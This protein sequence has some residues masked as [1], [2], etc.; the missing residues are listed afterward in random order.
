MVVW[1][2]AHRY[3]GFY[4]GEATLLLLG[5]GLIFSTTVPEWDEYDIAAWVVGGII[6]GGVTRLFT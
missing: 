4:M 3:G 2:L 5:T 6:L 1:F